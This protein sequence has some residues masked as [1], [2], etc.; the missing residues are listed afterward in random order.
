M[1][2][3]HPRWSPDGKFIAFDG[4]D[5]GRPTRIY[6]VSSHG[7]TPQGI[8]S[9]PNEVEPSWSP[10]GNSLLFGVWDAP[11]RT[12][13]G[14][15]YIADLKS[16]KIERVP[17]SE[18]VF[19][20]AWSADGRFIAATR[21]TGMMLFDSLTRRWKRLV[22]SAVTDSLFWSH[23][24][25]Y[26]YYQELAG[27]AGQPIWRVRISDGRLE[28]LMSSAQIPQA[29]VTGYTLNGLLYDALTHDDEPFAT[30]SLGNSDIYALDVDLPK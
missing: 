21:G 4:S 26:V 14:G 5:G 29:N 25:T 13:N 1:R 6:V 24:G 17:G 9:M 3:F 20:G 30:V 19:L 22:S 2:A 8:S 16:G 28:K 10:D 18:T 7:G 15:L 12:G 27:G 11:G 23:D